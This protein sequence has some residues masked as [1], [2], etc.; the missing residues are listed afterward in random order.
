MQDSH[1][2]LPAQF[3]KALKNVTQLT[4]FLVV[5]LRMSVNTNNMS[6]LQLAVYAHNLYVEESGTL[7]CGHLGNAATF[8]FRSI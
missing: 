1:D 5:K 3:D 4:L 2:D 8:Q 6:A 7:V